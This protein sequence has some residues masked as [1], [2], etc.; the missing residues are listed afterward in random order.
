MNRIKFYSSSDLSISFFVDRIEEVLKMI[1]HKKEVKNINDIIE[2]YNIQKF[3]DAKMFL[4]TW[5]ETDIEHYK[6]LISSNIKTISQFFKLINDNNIIFIYK[7]IDMYYKSDFWELID[8]LKIYKNISINIFYLLL[9]ESVNF[10]YEILKN[11]NISTYAGAAIRSYML[12]NPSS[13]ELLVEQF[14]FKHIGEQVYLYFPKDLDNK[15]KITIISNYIDSEDPNLNYLRLI[16]NIQSNKDKIEITP[17]IL[18][19]AKRK[20]EDLERQIFDDKSQIITEINAVFSKIAEKDYELK[21]E[22]RKIIATYS[23]KWINENLDY[24]TLLNNFIYLFNFVDQQMR[25]TLVTKFNH[26][27]V[28]ER[29]I[30]VTS[31]NAYMDGLAF[32]QVNSLSLLQIN[33]YY[34][35]LFSIGIRLENIIE[36]FFNDYLRNEFKLENFKIRMPSIHSTFF[37][38]CTNIMPAMESVLKQFS[39]YVQE[40]QIDLELLDIR[41]EHLVYKNI[42]SLVDKKYVYGIGDEYKRASFF[43]FSDQS[44][45]RYNNKTD[46]TY[47]NFYEWVSEERLKICD[48]PDYCVLDIKWLIEHN[49]LVVDNDDNIILVY[50]VVNILKDL[51]FNEVLC[52]WKYSDKG[53]KV[54]VELEKKKIVEFGNSL[55]SRPE[56]DYINFF[57]N[58][59][60][61]NNGLDLRNKYSHTQP[62]LNHDEKTHKIN[63]MTFLRLL[64]LCVI[65]IND[66]F[67]A[68]DDINKSL[69][70]EGFEFGKNRL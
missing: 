8:N 17:I 31:K 12:N 10:L 37:E 60:Q 57:L 26:M 24:A 3:F 50:G 4:K 33:A 30:L 7:D 36:W 23:V 47:E 20:I 27:S 5:T 35:L 15:D 1:E 61:F 38:K 32:Q 16:A 19:K 2:I 43:L 56:Q 28:F 41:S 70:G 11:K 34:D 48:Y 63:Y 62:C 51:Y 55:F 65:K 67:C 49:Y 42:P 21:L 68:L 18:L 54:I 13:A 44:C 39:L 58:K 6:S 53:R 46:K 14:E 69:I 59:S 66:D 9:N 25:C 64:I 40:G 52:Y 22:E 29:F 45:L